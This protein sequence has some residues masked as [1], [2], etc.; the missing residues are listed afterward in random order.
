MITLNASDARIP[1]D[2]FNKVAYKGERIRIV[3]R[4]GPAV[5]LVPE[6]DLDLLE[7]LEDQSDIR[8]AEKRLADLKA[9]KTKTIPLEKVIE[10]FGL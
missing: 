3:K 1:P 9:G 2:A 8:E 5:V 4:G 6:E 10:K 7:E